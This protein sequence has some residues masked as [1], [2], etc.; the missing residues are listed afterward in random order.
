M[1]VARGDNAVTMMMMMEA[2]AS[3]GWDEDIL[4]SEV[5]ALMV[6]SQSVVSLRSSE[7]SAGTRFLQ[8]P[9]S[10][11]RHGSLL[12]FVCLELHRELTQAHIHCHYVCIKKLIN[13]SMSLLI[14]MYPPRTTLCAFKRRCL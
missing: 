9:L 11:P 7:Q 12:S 4:R 10:L 14:K 2:I 13:Q 5:F 1:I 6:S 3:E 8:L